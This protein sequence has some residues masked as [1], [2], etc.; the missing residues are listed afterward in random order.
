MKKRTVSPSKRLQHV[1]DGEEVAQRLG[2]LLVVDVQEAVVH[3]VLTNGAAAGAFALRDLV[4]VVRELQVHAA[5][6]DVEGL[7]EQRAAHRRALDVPARAARGRRRWAT[8]R[9]RARRAWRPSTARSP[10]GL[11]CRRARPRARRRAARRAT[12]PR[13]CRSPGNLRTA[14]FT[15]PPLGPVG[16][17]LGLERVDHAPASAARSRWRAARASGGTVPS[18]AKS[19]CIAAIISSVSCADRDAALERAPDDLV[20]D[21]GDVAH[22]GDAGSRWRAASGRPRRR[23]SPCARGPCGTGRRP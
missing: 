23:P 18:A 19:R 7:A 2:H 6:V 14:K 9:R 11:P 13:A 16:Q 1:A 8:W 21:V 20:L 10:A 5:A 22:V 4:L 12:C 3:P 17:A 15:S